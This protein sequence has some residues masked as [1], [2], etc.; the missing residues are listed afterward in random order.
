MLSKTA[1]S[2]MDANTDKRIVIQENWSERNFV[3]KS[4]PEKTSTVRT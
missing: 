3:T 1:E 4:D 2:E